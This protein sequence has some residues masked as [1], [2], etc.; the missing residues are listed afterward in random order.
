MKPL[1]QFDL[2]LLVILE[3]LLSECHVSRAAEKVFL[4]QSAMSHALNRLREQLDDPLLVRTGNGL[5]PTPRATAL[6]PE[7]RKALQLVER[8]LMPEAPFQPEHSDRRFTIACTDYFEAVVLPQIIAHL[9]QEAPAIHIEVEMITDASSRYQLENREIDLIVGIDDGES[10]DSRLIQQHWITEQQVCLVGKHHL[11][12][13]D[14]LS[15]EQY[16]ELPHLVFS[17]LAGQ[18]SNTIDHWLKEQSLSRNHI[19]RTMNYM[20]AA[21]TIV[22]TDALITLPFNMARLFCEM[23]PVRMVSPPPGL[24]E[25]TMVT[26][27][28][29]LFSN[30][31]SIQWLLELINRIGQESTVTKQIT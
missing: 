23:L 14:Q 22:Q 6:L 2:N 7:V 27:H 5:Q 31:P 11:D 3:A 8:T 12:V 10:I 17:D 1:R 20:A 28:H 25:I 15:L 18:R 16:I 4:S 29:P 9:Q 26:I 19:A 21:R 24:P 13:S 30:D